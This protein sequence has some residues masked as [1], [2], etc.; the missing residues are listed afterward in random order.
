MQVDEKE[1]RF[2]APRPVGSV[3]ENWALDLHPSAGR[4]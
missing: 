1:M 3:V 2:G 4:S